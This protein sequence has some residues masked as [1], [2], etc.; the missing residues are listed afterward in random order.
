MKK[1]C[2]GSAIL[3][4]LRLQRTRTFDLCKWECNSDNFDEVNTVKTLD[5]RIRTTGSKTLIGFWLFLITMTMKNVIVND[6]WLTMKMKSMKNMKGSA[7]RAQ[8]TLTFYL[9]NYVCMT[10]CHWRFLW[11]QVNIIGSAHRAQKTP[12]SGNLGEMIL[13]AL[14]GSSCLPTSCWL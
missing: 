14:P 7:H 12:T 6:N 1:N 3:H 4:T 10:N 11:Q 2:K 9:C 8:K 5:Q 13:P